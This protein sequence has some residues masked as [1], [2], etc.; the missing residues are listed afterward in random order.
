M[1]LEGLKT[2]T[3]KANAKLQAEAAKSTVEGTL[4]T[5]ENDTGYIT[6]LVG[7]SKFGESNQMIRA[8]QGSLQPGSTFKPLYY[9]AAIDTRKYT[10]ASVINDTPVVFYNEDGVPY[11]P[12]NFKGEW[13][14]T[15][16][17]WK[18]LANSM[19]VPSVRILDGIGF[20]AAIGRAASLLGFRDKDQIDR[21][22]PRV[23]SLG[24]G[25]ISVSPIQMARAYATFANQG[26]EVTPIAI[27]SVEDRNGKTIL[28]PEKDLRLEQKRK[29]S[30][31]Q[32]LTPQNAYIMT[33]LLRNTIS[34][35]TLGYASDN[36]QKFT[37]KDKSGKKFVLP[38]AGKTGTTQNWADA[39]TVGFTPSTRR[40]CGSAST[41]AAFPS[42]STTPARRSRDRRGAI[43]WA[44]Y[45]KTCRTA[46][47]SNPRPGWSRRRS[48]RSRASCRRT[49]ATTER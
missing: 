31:I 33:E 32:I 12:L 15:V 24:L 21:T 3:N 14:G 44:G 49:P 5:I 11:T 46:T 43:T 13:Q 34:A 18:A 17:L 42:A 4:V 7:G 29:G 37:Y 40:R 2:E 8:T 36:E 41:G 20:D 35:G 48:A 25:V 38:A 1:G 27:R 23:Y 10:A 39:W 6:A 28:D 9:S 47:S 45:T 16:L 19:N 26:R 22:F 30:A